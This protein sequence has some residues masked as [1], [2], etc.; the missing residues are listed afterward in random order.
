[1]SH[2]IRY[3]TY[4]ENCNKKKVQKEW[5]AFVAHAD[6]QEGAKG[7]DSQIRW[8]EETI[9]D[10][11]EEAERFIEAHDKG[12]YDSL[13]VRYRAYFK[14]APNQRIAFLQNKVNELKQKY[15]ERDRRLCFAKRTSAFISCP[16]CQS[17]LARQ[18][19]KFNYCPVCHADMRS[20]TELG[21]LNN[22]SEQLKKR[23]TELNEEIKTYNK[24]RQDL[25]Q[26]RWLVKIE[27]HT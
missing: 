2:N 12:W 27:Y 10:S 15:E 26:I 9:C 1:M 24:K 20:K 5:D 14:P 11:Y 21:I 4:P 18:Y 22:M 8:I 6:Y 17:K 16:H 13:A 7:L 23:R 19:L 25:A 3:E